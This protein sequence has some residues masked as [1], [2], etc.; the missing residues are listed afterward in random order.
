MNYTIK[1]KVRAAAAPVRRNDKEGYLNTAFSVA[2]A[3][4]PV[5]HF[6]ADAIPDGGG[7]EAWSSAI[8]T[9]RT[10]RLGAG[11]RPFKAIVDAWTLGDLVLTH[12]RLDP[13]RQQRTID[14]AREDGCD[15]IQLIFV[16]SGVVTFRLDGDPEDLSVRA[17]ELVMFDTLRAIV[18]ETTELDCI[19]CTVARRVFASVGFDP[20]S[21]HGVVVDGPWGR[22]VADYL[23]SLLEALPQM[24]MGDARGLA[25]ALVSLL[26]AALRGRAPNGGKT[27]ARSAV[28][29]RQRVEAFVER[30]LDSHA[31]TP[32]ALASELATS[33]AT[34]YRAFAD[35]GGVSAYIRRRRLEVTHARLN[36]GERRAIGELARQCGFKSAAHFSR[37][38]RSQFG[39]S[40]RRSQGWSN[41]IPAAI[42]A[43]SVALFRHWEKRLRAGGQEAANAGHADSLFSG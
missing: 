9:H 40:P 24:R 7:F 35:V 4:I 27:I 33:E 12:S 26:V 21:H 29:L 3:P 28:P 20:F 41:D 1:T 18:G 36:S 5:L 42:A 39:F 17:G 30:N 8:V 23:L 25:E 10:A 22:L 6:D 2:D 38:F 15:W 31:L 19:T 43:D 34:L 11:D 37:A 16:R 32:Q 13:T 14:M